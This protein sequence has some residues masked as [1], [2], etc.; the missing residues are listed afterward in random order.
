MCTSTVDATL[1]ARTGT[2]KSYIEKQAQTFSGLARASTDVRLRPPLQG[3]ICP[4]SDNPPRR[5]RRAHPLSPERNSK[6]KCISCAP[7][8][9]LPRTSVSGAVIG[10]ES[11]DVAA[12]ESMTRIVPAR[13]RKR[14]NRASQGFSRIHCN[15]SFH[16]FMVTCTPSMPPVLGRVRSYG[17]RTCARADLPKSRSSG[18]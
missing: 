15:A 6:R 2:L 8:R 14:A 12:K 9:R 13:L 11:H 4:S 17:R 5:G 7:G 10:R 3:M 18:C 16:A 1:V